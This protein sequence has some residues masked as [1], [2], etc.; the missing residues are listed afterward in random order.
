MKKSLQEDITQISFEYEWEKNLTPHQRGANLTRIKN[1]PYFKILIDK[2]LVPYTDEWRKASKYYASKEKSRKPEYIQKRKERDAKRLDT[3]RKDP[4][5]FAE[6]RE[7]DR[8]RKEKERGTEEG[9]QRYNARQRAGYRKNR[10]ANARRQNERRRL[11]EPHRTIRANTEL[12]RKGL[13]TYEQ[14]IQSINE[15]VE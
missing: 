2:G 9:R 13:L 11:R 3:L 7:K 1:S 12:Y 15:S 6:Y 4:Q 8:E 10:E 5:K 14:Y